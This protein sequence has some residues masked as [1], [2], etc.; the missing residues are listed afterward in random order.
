MAKTIRMKR[1]KT[2]RQA[3][4]VFTVARM[5]RSKPKTSAKKSTKKSSKKK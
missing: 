3:G 2:K 4:S 1:A 5:T